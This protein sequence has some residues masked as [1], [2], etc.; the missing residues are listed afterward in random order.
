MS[1]CGMVSLMAVPAFLVRV[2]FIP[3][4]R[5]TRVGPAKALIPT[6]ISSTPKPD[7][8]GRLVGP[9]TQAESPIAGMNDQFASRIEIHR[10]SVKPLGHWRSR[11]PFHLNSPRFD[12]AFRRHYGRVKIKHEIYLGPG[13][14]ERRPVDGIPDPITTFT[15]S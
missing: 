9:L 1:L 15:S 5:S 14:G 3:E 13:P 7:P 10:A 6:I 12:L 11:A 8:K 2:L 4:L